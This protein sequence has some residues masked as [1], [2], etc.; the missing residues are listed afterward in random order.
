MNKLLIFT[1]TILFSLNTLCAQKTQGKI[2]YKG[3]MNKSF[4]NKKDKA[5][6]LSMLDDLIKRNKDV[7]F[8]LVFN[9]NEALYELKNKLDNEDF[10]LK[11][12]KVFLGGNVIHY[13]NIKT[14]ESLYQID[15]YGELFIVKTR[16][17]N[18]TL[19]KETKKIGKYNCFKAMTYK[20][21]ENSKGTFRH[22][23]TAWY[24]PEIPISFGP[25]GYY[26]LPGLILELQERNLNFVASKIDLNIEYDIKISKPKKGKV[27]SQKEF[28]ELGKKIGTTRQ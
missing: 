25:K 20:I 9:N 16:K 11:L 13:T 5:S 15:T 7:E 12:T 3:I 1:L 2:V 18:W 21:V 8:E 22:N 26:G 6:T 17:I 23:V 28:D 24:T 14:D 27:M 10:K 4:A 19:S